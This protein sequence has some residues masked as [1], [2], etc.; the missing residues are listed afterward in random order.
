M[1]IKLAYEEPRSSTPASTL[2]PPPSAVPLAFDT[3][4]QLPAPLDNAAI[5]KE[6]LEAGQLISH[7]STTIRLSAR[8]LEGHR[9][10][11]AP[12]ALGE[13]ITS[14]GEPFGKALRP[15]APGE[16]LRN[17]KVIAALLP[18]GLE[19]GFTPNFADY[20]KPAALSEASFVPG[21]PVPLHRL[22]ATFDGFV[23][24]P[25][26]RG[27]GTR[28]YLV[29]LP[30]SSRSNAFARALE[31]RVAP[32]A[33]EEPHGGL[34]GAVALPHTE[35]GGSANASAARN[36]T[37]LVRHLDCDGLRGCDGLR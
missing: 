28:N 13:L 32:A 19:P 8:V 11:V 25:A 17:A 31:R 29:I 1:P 7:A 23:R 14:W 18:R 20:V 35:D 6:D 2:T 10:A 5:A 36:Q 27:V 3:V 26:S 24:A 30:L 33:R 34:D 4:A 16:W 9:F 37:H 15:I 21:P 12:I 22:D